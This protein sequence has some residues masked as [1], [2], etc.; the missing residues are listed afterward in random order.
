MVAS[1]L[2]KGEDGPLVNCVMLLTWPKRRAMVQQAIEGFVRQ[3]HARKVL[4]LVNDGA[5][6][7]LSADFL[8]AHRG[9]VV[10]AP[11]ASSI[12]AKRNLG[13]RAV[14]DAEFIATFDDDDLSLPTRLETHLASI[15][16]GVAHRMNRWFVAIGQLDD[17]AGFEWASG[18]GAC[19]L[20]TDAA[21]RV[22]W[23]DKSY[24][25]DHVL[26]EQLRSDPATAGR[27]PES[28]ELVYVHRRHEANVS[29]PH[30]KDVRQ[31]LL[32]LQL[33]GADCADALRLIRELSAAG[34]LRSYLCDLASPIV[35][36]IHQPPIVVGQR[37][38]V[39]LPC[40]L[41]A[42]R[43]T[44]ATLDADDGDGGGAGRGRAEAGGTAWGDG[45]GTKGPSAEVL[46]EGDGREL[47]VHVRQLSALE[48]FELLEPTTAPGPLALKEQG[49]RLLALLDASAALGRYTAALKLLAAS[50]LPLASGSCVLVRPK[51]KPAKAG[52][53]PR[54]VR[55]AI[56]ATVEPA[57][58]RV[59]GSAEE[60][61]FDLVYEEDGEG[62][63]EAEM[64]DDDDDDELVPRSR[65]LP[66]AC[67]AAEGM[68]ASSAS[69]PADLQTQLYL[70]CCR[71]S[72]RRGE[73]LEPIA[74]AERALACALHV[75]EPERRALLL[76][77]A[78][79]LLAR[80]E[81]ARSNF[82]GAEA[83]AARGGRLAPA[84]REWPALVSEIA[85]KR[86]EH[87]RQNRR[88]AKEFSHWLGGVTQST[89]GSSAL[90]AVVGA[91]SGAAR[92]EQGAPRAVALASAQRAAGSPGLLRLRSPGGLLTA[93]LV[94][95]AALLLAYDRRVLLWLS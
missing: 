7:V 6:C 80:A 3:T 50:A 91:A 36:R 52:S 31:G 25:E 83:A 10:E 22:G 29:A 54:R 21:L 16:D 55:A 39:R 23:P 33:A 51:P 66:V 65:L 57:T 77:K 47:R 26:F 45:Q 19:L 95:I 64:D 35:P 68:R 84:D 20:R 59:G 53:A 90:A 72:S 87:T 88:L 78:L 8:A 27:L 48:P 43:A 24:L 4:T 49:N 94:L 15:G 1:S 38:R 46:L 81:L 34:A 30:R 11:H 5:P 12:G 75:R 42:E 89:A 76:G 14:P 92:A 18:Y 85:R 73:R 2:R 37:V 13:A 60:Q 63:A 70:N 86:A 67:A 40:G 44:V 41:L 56:V 69:D 62:E 79:Y 71:A 58:A 28:S 74:W 93:F 61:L 32:P 9:A 82:K 17:I